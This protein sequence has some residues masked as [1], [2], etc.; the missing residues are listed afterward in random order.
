[1]LHSALCSWD[2][3]GGSTFY[4]AALPGWMDGWMD[5]DLELSLIAVS[6]SYLFCNGHFLK[7]CRR[8]KHG[9]NAGISCNLCCQ[10]GREDKDLLFKEKKNPD[11]EGG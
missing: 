2:C 4:T 3:E 1:M 11:T 7:R 5:G 9:S 10:V 8:E 6:S